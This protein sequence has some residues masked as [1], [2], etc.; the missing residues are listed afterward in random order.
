MYRTLL[1]CLL[2][3]AL[4]GCALPP[5]RQAL[6]PLPENGPP[7]PF[8]ELIGRARTQASVANEAFYV[9]NWVELEDAAKALELT[10]HALSKASEVPARHKDK[11]ELEASDLSQQAIVLRDAA[12]AKEVKQANEVLQR[13]H[14]KIRELRP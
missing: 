4:S 7:Q 5:E 2:L 1:P 3:L 13:I 9:N 14:L 6:K 11:L 10:A 12:K 8:L